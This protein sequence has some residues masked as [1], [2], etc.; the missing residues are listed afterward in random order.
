MSD[1]FP[2]PEKMDF[3]GNVAEKWKLFEQAFGYYLNATG[4]AS[5]ADKIKIWVLMSCIGIEGMHIFNTFKY[6]EA[7]SADKYD[8]VIKKFKDYCMP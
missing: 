7:E 8:D 6:D 3:S 5:K 4:K 1:R 2:L